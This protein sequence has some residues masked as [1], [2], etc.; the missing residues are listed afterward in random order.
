MYVQGVPKKLIQVFDSFG[1]KVGVTDFPENFTSGTPLAEGSEI[2]NILNLSAQNERQRSPKL[3]LLQKNWCFGGFSS[4]LFR[5][6]SCIFRNIHFSDGLLS[7]HETNEMHREDQFFV[8]PV[9]CSKVFYVVQFHQKRG[10]KFDHFSPI[11]ANIS[12]TK[13]RSRSCRVSKEPQ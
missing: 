10:S 7:F 8:R 3:N 4:H 5:G 2:R 12:R 13:R 9:R 11:F 1:S 6:F